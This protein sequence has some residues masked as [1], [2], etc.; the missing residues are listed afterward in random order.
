M[1]NQMIIQYSFVFC[2]FSSI[3]WAIVNNFDEFFLFF[4]SFLFFRFLCNAYPCLVYYRA[5]R[6]KVLVDLWFDLQMVI[7]KNF[8][9][10][11]PFF[12]GGKK[13]KN[14][15]CKNSQKHNVQRRNLVGEKILSSHA[16]NNACSSLSLP[17]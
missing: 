5:S 17:I 9:P 14:D 10:L 16:A 11:P 12:N 3:I 8:F 13:N 1:F 15:P 4:L 7:L 6:H 2:I